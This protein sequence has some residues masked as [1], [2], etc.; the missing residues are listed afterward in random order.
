MVV[1]PISGGDDERTAL[2][3]GGG[4]RSRAGCVPGRFESAPQ[5]ADVVGYD[6]VRVQF[7]V[8]AAGDV[9]DPVAGVLAPD[10][11]ARELCP[12]A[13]EL[14]LR[15][16]RV[17]AG[18]PGSWGGASLRWDGA[19]AGVSGFLGAWIG[20]VHGESLRSLAAL[21]LTSHS[22]R[23]G[24]YAWVEKSGCRDNGLT[25]VRFSGFR[26]WDVADGEGP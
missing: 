18:G 14:V 23:A 6:S 11:E 5:F 22:V 9:P 26:C 21:L 20:V 7:Q 1:S 25:D 19:R 17:A 15:Q 16:G 4:V 24:E 8:Q 12:Q 10:P 3:A 2:G 13:G